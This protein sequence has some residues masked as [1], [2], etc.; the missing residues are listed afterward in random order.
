MYEI[1]EALDQG[2]VVKTVTRNSKERGEFYYLFKERIP[3]QF[4]AGD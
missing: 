2:L 4:P 1:L 3:Y